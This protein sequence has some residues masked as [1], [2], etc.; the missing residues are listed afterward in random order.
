VAAAAP[1][2]TRALNYGLASFLIVLS[3]MTGL[4]SWAT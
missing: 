3:A 4:Y 1:S 2:R